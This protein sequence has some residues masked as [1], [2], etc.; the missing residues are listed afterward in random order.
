MD[1]FKV[2]VNDKYYEFNKSTFHYFIYGKV[3]KNSIVFNK[4]NII[5][6]MILN[7]SFNGLKTISI[8]INNVKNYHLELKGGTDNS[9]L[10][11]NVKNNVI[12]V[13][14]R[15]A[16]EADVMVYSLIID[17]EYI[18]IEIKTDLIENMVYEF[19]KL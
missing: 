18:N 16:V 10:E 14:E 1:K 15:S 3:D 8:I 5:I 7:K 13:D 4:N 12:Y 17:I 9:N 2:L 11:I 6:P 19:S